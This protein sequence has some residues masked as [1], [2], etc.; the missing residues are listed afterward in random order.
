MSTFHVTDATARRGPS[1]TFM[2]PG[3][4]GVPVA[5]GYLPDAMEVRESKREASAQSVVR[6][7]GEVE[8]G[9]N[10]VEII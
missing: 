4:R 1:E 5:V 8:A 2:G 10:G 7:G 6:K 9:W 3:L